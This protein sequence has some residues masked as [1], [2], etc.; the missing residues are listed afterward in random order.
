MASYKK[1]FGWSAA[2]NIALAVGFLGLC[3]Y[4]DAPRSV[5]RRVFGWYLRGQEQKGA[6][7][8]EYALLEKL[9]REEP[10]LIVAFGDSITEGWTDVETCDP[11]RVYHQQLK[12]RLHERFPHAVVNVIN[13]GFRGDTLERALRRLDGDVLRY[14]PDLVLVEFGL[15]DCIQD[16]ADGVGRFRQRLGT[17]IERLRDGCEADLILLTPNFMVTEDNPNVIEEHRER[18]WIEPLVRLQSEG[19]LEAY[20]EAI[21]QVGTEQGAA[22]ADVYAKWQALADE[23]VDTNRLL[24]NGLNHPNAEGHRM[25]AEAVLEALTPAGEPME[26]RQ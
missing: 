8:S 25:I 22:V 23:G 20:V 14:E 10:G 26:L 24:A 15:N 11:E 17:V 7:D 1:L 13:S 9:G 6:P 5:A 16:G 2:L 3:W 18:G 12:E 21:R 4:F 19:V